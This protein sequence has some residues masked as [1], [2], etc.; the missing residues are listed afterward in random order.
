MIALMRFRQCR[1]AAISATWKSIRAESND[2][3][4]LLFVSWASQSAL[5][6]ASKFRLWLST[7]GFG[8]ICNGI[9]SVVLFLIRVLVM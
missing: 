5:I 4:W 6:P 1:P 7:T 2:S 3:L 8:I 9:P